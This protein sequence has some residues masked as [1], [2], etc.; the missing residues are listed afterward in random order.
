MTRARSELVDLDVTSYYHCMARCVRRAF[1]FGDDFAT[2]Q[3]YD[4]RK[5]WIVERLKL[6]ASIFAIDVC[7]YAILSN[8]IHLVL[9]VMAQHV[10]QWSDDE[11]ICRAGQLCP[12]VVVGMDS[13]TK[14][15]RQQFI[16]T[17][18]LRLCDVSWFMSRL[19]EHIARRA[20]EEDKCTGRFWEGRFDSNALL[21][22]AALL[23]AM[24]YVDLN[25]VHAG[26]A[27]GL[28]DSTW[29][30]IHQRL[31]EVA[32]SMEQEEVG[33]EALSSAQGQDS[34]SDEE[35]LAEL[36]PLLETL[37][38]ASAE[39]PGKPSLKQ[40]PSLAPMMDHSSDFLP[41]TLLDYIALLEWKG[42][43]PR[44]DKKGFI[45][46]HISRKALAKLGLDPDK[47][48]NSVDP[49]SSFGGVVGQPSKL[50]AR[51]AQL[52]KKWLKGQG[53]ST[54]VYAKAA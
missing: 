38:A 29:T 3:N 36:R 43:Q 42:S 23:S 44:K 10:E 31:V 54:M 47:W 1:L 21:D 41:I 12:T 9:R 34:D 48:R 30:S 2:G 8:H 51:A 33:A 15:K 50:Q 24:S 53:S 14:K 26:I 40:F 17:W 19:D 18:R 13:W 4:H 45:V 25:P 37:A 5:V 49:F 52:G 11:I 7:A 6:L 22:G 28:V 32:G 46:E 16:E 35:T 27:A 39:V 20:N